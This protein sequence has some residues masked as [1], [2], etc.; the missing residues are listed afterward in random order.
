MVY[1]KGRRSL[2]ISLVYMKEKSQIKARCKKRKVN[3]QIVTQK[4]DRRSNQEKKRK[5]TRKL[6]FSQEPKESALERSRQK[7]K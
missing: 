1:E 7:N 6:E 4:K 3:Y 2:V 5:L